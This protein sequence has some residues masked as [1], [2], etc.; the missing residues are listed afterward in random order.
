MTGISIPVA[1]MRAD[2]AALVAGGAA[3]ALHASVPSTLDAPLLIGPVAIASCRSLAIFL[4][5]LTCPTLVLASRLYRKHRRDD[6]EPTSRDRHPGRFTQHTGHFVRSLDHSARCMDRFIRPRDRF[7]RDAS[8]AARCPGHLMRHL[9]RIMLTC[10]LCAS[11]WTIFAEGLLLSLTITHV[12]NPP[13]PA[14]DRVVA[15]HY[16]FLLYGET[17]AYVVPGGVGFG[18]YYATFGCDD[19]VD[20]VARD[21]YALAWHGNQPELLVTGTAADPVWRID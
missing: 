21:D 1:P 16:N 11:V 5:A 9:S 8:R 6:A 18:E 19:G 15:V 4:V 20:P 17:T 7:A 2:L 14:G 10:A 3:L 13:S 12:L